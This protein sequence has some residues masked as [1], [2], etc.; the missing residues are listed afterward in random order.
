MLNVLQ[1]HRGSTTYFTENI[2]VNK[3]LPLHEL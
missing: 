2:Y 1:I 3:I